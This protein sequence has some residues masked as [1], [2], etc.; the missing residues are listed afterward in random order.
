MLHNK[1]DYYSK[2]QHKTVCNKRP[3][4]ISNDAHAY[5]I[6]ANVSRMQT[7]TRRAYIKDTYIAHVSNIENLELS[8][9][10]RLHGV[11]DWDQLRILCERRN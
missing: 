6:Y 2:A 1:R 10:M 4:T 5:F 11:I 9:T 3:I 7:H 8:D